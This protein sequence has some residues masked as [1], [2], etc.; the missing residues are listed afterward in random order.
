MEQAT[1]S[2]RLRLMVRIRGIMPG[3][4]AISRTRPA[5]EPIHR[6]R[7]GGAIRHSVIAREWEK[8]N[9]VAVMGHARGGSAQSADLEWLEDGKHPL[10]WDGPTSR[11]FTRFC[12]K[13]L[14]RSIID[15][16]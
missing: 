6:A 16:F 13:N 11:I 8:L 3:A 1:E 12:D 5:E 2:L 10:D 15:H 4:G 7:R 9:P 14:D